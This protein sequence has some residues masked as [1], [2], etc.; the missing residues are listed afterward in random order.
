[1]DNPLSVVLGGFANVTLK[2]DGFSP[3][4]LGSLVSSVRGLSIPDSR[5]LISSTLGSL[6]E[7]ARILPSDSAAFTE[8]L[9]EGLESLKTDTS[10]VS[11]ILGPIG[12][13][14][15]ALTPFIGQTDQLA[16][17]TTQIGSVAT[18][19]IDKAAG[20]N[21]TN[22][23]GQ[24]DA[25]SQFLD[26]FPELVSVGPLAELRGQIDTLKAWLT[27]GSAD[28]SELF[29]A[30]IQAVADVLSG[31]LNAAAQVGVGRLTELQAQLPALDRTT[32]C[33]PYGAA[34]DA[35]ATIDTTDFTQ[36]D[37]YLVLVDGKVAQVTAAANTLAQNVQAMLDG[38]EQLEAGR[39]AQNL[40]YALLDIF[41]AV[42]PERPGP[43]A[44]FFDQISKMVLQLNLDS[45]RKTVEDV[46]QRVDEA[47]GGLHLGELTTT[48]EQISTRLAST[49]GEVD[50]ALVSVAAALSNLV[51]QLRDLLKNLKLAQLVNQVQTALGSLSDRVNELLP[52][53]TAVRGQ[54]EGFVSEVE[55]E[56]AKINMADLVSA[57][58][59]FLDQILGVLNNPDIKGVL[60][61][62][63]NGI[64]AMVAKLDAVSLTPIFDQVIE[65][66]N[67]AKGKAAEIDV[68]KLNDMLKVALA[69][70]VAV[71]REVD[72]ASQIAQGL[73]DEFN[74]ILTAGGDLVAPLHEKYL[75]IG[76]QL[77]VFAP[78]KIIADRLQPPYQELLDG[79][80]A[81]EPAKILEPLGNVYE[82]LLSKLEPLSPAALL[83]P[84]TDLHGQVVAL[85][86]SL[87]PAT[88]I[89]P[90]NALLGEVTSILDALGIEPLMEKMTQTVN[91]LNGMLDGLQIGDMLRGTEAWA[92]LTN[93]Q[94]QGSSVLDGIETQVDAFMD[95]MASSVAAV[96]M[97]VLQ[98]ALTALQG[99]IAAVEGHV[100][101][102]P[103]LVGIGVI[104]NA[105][106]TVDFDGC[107]ANLTQKWTAQKARFAAVTP[108]PEAADQFAL[109][110]QHVQELSPIVVLATPAALMSQARTKALAA[111]A[112]L[113]AGQQAMV[114]ALSQGQ[115]KLSA[116][117]PPDGTA[118]GFAQMLRATLEAEIGGPI[119]A[120][121][122]ALRLR[123][124]GLNDLI[125]ASLALAIKLQAPFQALGVVPEGLGSM[126]AALV[127]A[128][129][130]ITG[131]NLNFLQD[132]LQGVVDEAVAQLQAANPATVLSELQT[133][134]SNILQALQG[135][136]PESAIEAL[137][138]TYQEQIVK[139]FADLAPAETIGKPLDAKFQQLLQLKVVLSLD[140][141]FEALNTKLETL[142]AEMEDGLQCTAEAFNELL[143][144]LPSSATLSVSVSI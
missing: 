66:I 19:I 39:L 137:N 43:L 8:A 67:E 140:V 58:Q 138:T 7:M 17:M 132:E 141:I 54:V 105:L 85:L 116:L 110:K 133:V 55:Q 142:G 114:A 48:V 6:G 135:L 77:D 104:T 100:H 84:L 83:A 123:L 40:Q 102:S 25:I 120:L 79:L 99:A 27:L 115:D 70:A 125:Q 91:Q 14:I 62:A 37:G 26:L 134:Y 128:K 13:L 143:T 57:L 16:Q 3:G 76:G 28:L 89:A 101:A 46:G 53:V 117:L 144:A 106:G 18:D 111:E 45:A 93:A 94:G 82:E 136:Y 22:I 36:V 20:L 71:V 88:L 65:Q 24:L 98:P 12:T 68:S 49:V 1:L 87:S 2:V 72:F 61:N 129:N 130:K 33:A 75:E 124:Q 90:L 56:L 34:L 121:V 9:R 47:L 30:R 44:V 95:E 80:E 59:G 29:R 139:K 42:A 86:Q 51:K 38:L 97:S 78:G 122:V 103:V 69:A 92:T 60:D 4:D 96:D 10:A 23:A 63:K 119:K 32:W 74:T 108:P 35:L 107:M 11:D 126:A 113:A 81:I 131:F 31:P 21:L 64:G 73:S 52:T 109:L 41:S 127:E 118:A 50:R 5:S 15:E 112:D